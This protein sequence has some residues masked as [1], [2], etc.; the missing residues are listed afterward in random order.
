M[1]LTG[2][3]RARRL[4]AA[5]VEQAKAAAPVIGSAE[6]YASLNVAQVLEALSRGEFTPDVV[7][8]F[9]SARPEP[10]KTVLA[11]ISESE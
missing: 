6:H 8:E 3:N 9:E 11:A 5:K 2:F 1:G 10:R 7:R 4:A